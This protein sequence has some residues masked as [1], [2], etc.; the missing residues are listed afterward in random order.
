M[1]YLA[2]ISHCAEDTWVARQL[3]H[4]CSK[5]GAQT[6]LDEAQI[7][8]GANFEHDIITALQKAN[9]LV[10]LITPWALDRPYVWLEIG[11]AWI[12]GIPIIAILLGVSIS[13]FQ[14]KANVPVALKQ[15]NLLPLNNV[16]RY[17]NE[18]SARVNRNEGVV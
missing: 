10:V 8:V 5:V 1:S 6:F 13:Q 12:R 18:L 16:D 2:F 3:S 4:E 9:E 7:A 14:E 17:I 11:A 15:R